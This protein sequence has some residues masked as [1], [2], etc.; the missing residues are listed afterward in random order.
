MGSGK[1]G[2]RPS[3]GFS[4]KADRPSL[5]AVHRGSRLRHRDRAQALWKAGK[6]QDGT[7]LETRSSLLPLVLNLLLR[8]WGY[9][10]ERP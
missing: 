9:V 6:D 10:Q 5:T 1:N 2:V 3:L 4:F 7:G 8:A